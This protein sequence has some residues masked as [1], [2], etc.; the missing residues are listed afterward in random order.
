MKSKRFLPQLTR[1]EACCF[2]L[3]GVL[4][5]GLAAFFHPGHPSGNAAVTGTFAVWGGDTFSYLDPIE[6]L[7]RHGI[8]AQ[9]LARLD[10]YAGRMP[11][12]G[13]VYGLLRLV[14]GPGTAADGVM[15]L[16][17][18][19]SLASVYALGRLAQAV[20]QRPVAF[21]WAVLLYGASTFAITF[22]IRLLT[23][24]FATSALII[25]IYWLHQAHRQPL[26]THAW[27]LGAGLWLGWAVFLRPFLAPW[28]GLVIVSHAAWALTG[29]GGSG[30]RRLHA[31]RTVLLALPFLVADGVWVARNWPW[32]H[33]VVP[34]QSS[35]WAGYQT[36]PGFR[37]LDDFVGTIG[38]E[39]LYWEP[40]R[41]ISWFYKPLT[42]PAPNFRG[43]TSKL[44]PPAYTYDSLLLVRRY[45]LV[46]QDDTRPPAFR[47]AAEARASRALNRYSRAYRQLRPFHAFV[48]VPL[49]L[50]YRLT[51]AHPGDY[52][53]RQPFAELVAW[54]K[55]VKA[56]AHLWYLVIVGLGLIGTFFVG[57]RPHF[58]ELL[59][60][61][62]PVYLIVLLCVVLFKVEFRY[63]AV[64]Y[65]FVLIGTVDVLLAGRELVKR[66]RLAIPTTSPESTSPVRTAS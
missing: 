15:V 5:L 7:L 52:L 29:N 46:A 21:Q 44:A 36:P 66:K 45:L 50:M 2:L 19:L 16:Q 12:Y 47:R 64:A 53:F 8:Y 1:S 18:L 3:A 28:F 48:L 31:F 11:G 41:D 43:E 17:L 40:A 38:E 60:K 57:W 61:S 62:V 22:D 20:T 24:S 42:D 34:V 59:V 26:P 55:V 9:D 56:G 63:F 33:R 49:K 14:A 27:W 32:Y 35:Y 13:A 23:E 10:T 58:V 4:R 6:N 25:G 37:A 54:K 30:R 51:L 65:P 39:P